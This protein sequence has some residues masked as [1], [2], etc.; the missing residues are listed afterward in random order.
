MGKQLKQLGYPEKIYLYIVI[1]VGSLVAMLFVTSTQLPE[2]GRPP[3]LFLVWN[4]FLAW[5]PAGLALVLDGISLLRTKSLRWML[6]LIAGGLWLFFY[7]NAAYLITDLLHPFARLTIEDSY[8]FWQDMLFWNHLFTVLLTALL[9]LVLGIISLASV[10]RL[11]ERALGRIAGIVFA[12]AV[13]L[14]SSFGVYLGRFFRFNS[15]DVLHQ[16]VGLLR[17]ILSYFTNM[18]HVLHAYSYCK[19]I[20]LITGFGYMVFCLFGAMNRRMT[21]G[22]D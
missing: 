3:Y 20:F 12:A 15:W 18:E 8:L 14:L 4:T 17:Q 13:L 2:G 9:G 1:F 10:H 16:P 19:W 5:V 7:P 6:Y 11:V 22:G 21:Q